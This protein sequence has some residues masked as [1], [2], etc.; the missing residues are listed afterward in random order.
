VTAPSVLELRAVGYRYAGYG[1]PAI[2]DVDLAIGRGEIVGLV[3][4]NGAGKSTVCL[5]A[6]G[7]APGSIG[8]EL[9]GDVVLPAGRVGIVFANPASQLSGVAGTV[10]EEVAWGPINLGLPVAESVTRARTALTALGIDDLAER[11]PDRLSG[12]QMQLVAI[13][14]MLAM[15]PS[16]LVLDEPLAELDTGGR[17]LVSAA[18]G[19]LAGSGTALLIAEHDLDALGSL[20]TRLVAIDDCRIVFDL[21]TAAALADPRLRELGVGR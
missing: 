10:F 12:G 11:R 16:C 9:T 21:P 14:S 8:G 7:L 6:A 4:P 1:R 5:V 20:C 13:A 17:E 3:G 2:T 18:L 19:A 15:G